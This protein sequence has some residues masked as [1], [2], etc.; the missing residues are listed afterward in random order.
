MLLSL[1]FKR[2]DAMEKI[3]TTR[4][5]KGISQSDDG[6]MFKNTV[7]QRRNVEARNQSLP[8]RVNNMEWSSVEL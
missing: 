3:R 2:T 4:L 6:L 5:L 7:V 1:M 8:Y